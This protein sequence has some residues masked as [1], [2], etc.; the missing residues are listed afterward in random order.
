VVAKGDS[1]WTISRANKI[2]LEELKEAN[3]QISGTTLSIGQKVK[4]TVANPYINIISKEKMT[5]TV[6]VAYKE[7]VKRDSS[8]WNWERRVVTRGES[9]SKRVVY[10][11]TRRNGSIVEK[12]VISETVLKAPVAQVIVKG[13]KTDTSALIVGTGRFL[14]PVQGKITS[15]YG[16]RSGGF[17]TGVDIAAPYKTPIRAADDGTVKV[18]AYSSTGYGNRVELNHGNGFSTLYAHCSSFNVRV[19]Q[20]VRKG[21]IIAYVGSTGRSSGNHCHFEIRVNGQ[22]VN[23]MKYY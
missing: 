6:K 2:S 13:T 5:E 16:Y 3:P 18:A 7:E 19:G 4:L 15:P 23:P 10:E 17:H 20:V 1:L 8:L 14:W 9:G 12:K 11:V 22:H 21:D